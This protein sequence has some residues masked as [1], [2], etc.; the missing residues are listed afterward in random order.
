MGKHICFRKANSHYD[1]LLGLDTKEIFEIGQSHEISDIFEN[2]TNEVYIYIG[3]YR[4]S[5]WLFRIFYTLP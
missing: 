1:P 5:S 2:M 3:Y 4:Y